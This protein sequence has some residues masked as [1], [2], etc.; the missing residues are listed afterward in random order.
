[1]MSDKTAISEPINIAQFMSDWGSVIDQKLLEEFSDEAKDVYISSTMGISTDM[2]E[3]LRNVCR[4]VRACYVRY[5]HSPLNKCCL[6]FNTLNCILVNHNVY[7][8]SN[9]VMLL[10]FKGL[11]CIL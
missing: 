2:S 10:C 5:Y 1:M 11:C 3:E 9:S 6:A 8:F 7:I 4:Y